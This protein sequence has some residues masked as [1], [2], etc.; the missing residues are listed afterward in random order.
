MQPVKRQ[1]LF[2][3]LSTQEAATVNGAWGHY[4]RPVYFCYPVSWSG[5]S[6]SSPSVNQTVNVNVQIDD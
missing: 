3:D 4:Y 6:G 1:S 2:T 5:S